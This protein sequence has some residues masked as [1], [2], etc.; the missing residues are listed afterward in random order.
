MFRILVIDDDLDICLVLS[1][2][3]ERSHYLVDT[4]STGEEGLLKL[5]DHDY[6]LV[7]CDYKLP[8]ISGLELLKQ[9]KLTKPVVAVIIITGY[10]DIK[11]AVET[12][13]YGADDFMIKPLY[14]HELLINIK[15]AITKNK[16]S[17]NPRLAQTEKKNTNDKT[18]PALNLAGES[19]AI[20][21]ENDNEYENV[22]VPLPEKV[23]LLKSIA[24]TAERQAI[25]DTLIK[26]NY[27]KS[28][29]A[30]LLN[31]DRKTLYNKLKLYHITD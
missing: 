8:D 14:P 27:N 19:E 9:I 29:A 10:S 17:I 22:Y 26:V 7:L 23:G 1:A 31:I 24:W 6:D 15:E 25:I 28:R 3:L 12:L 13:R 16:L 30:G 21:T 20:L 4:T 2:L 18:K 11:T 5:R